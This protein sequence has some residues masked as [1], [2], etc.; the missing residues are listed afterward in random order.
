MTSI[1]YNEAL[2]KINNLE[3]A[4]NTKSNLRA[5]LNK[6]K[7][8]KL[9]NSNEIY[10]Y[11]MN[12]KKDT[13]E[14]TYYS[15]VNSV[16][17]L[18]TK[19]IIPRPNEYDKLKDY[20]KELKLV[21]QKNTSAVPSDKQNDNYISLEELQ[22]KVK[23]IDNPSDRL[24]VSLYVEIPPVRLDY[25]NVKIVDKLKDIPV[26]DDKQNYYAIRENTI[27]LRDYK[28]KKKYGEYQYKL[29]PEH[30]KLIQKIISNTG[31]TYLFINPATNSPYTNNKF[32]VYLTEVFTKYF[33]KSI[34]LLDLRHIYASHY[35]IEKYGMDK[36]KE[37]ANRML[38]SAFANVVE[39]Q[40]NYYSGN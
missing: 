5:V 4:T 28:T 7:K 22:S 8:N 38:H 14:G 13:K 37:I 23:S 18:M 15:Y 26:E 34:T 6:L 9:S 1:N 27:V 39:Y 19:E 29:L 33:N 3:L 12:I 31:Q 32:G 24:L 10:E 20:L 40:K 35:S 11:L 36:V 25:A 2:N 30:K 16:L 21:I 17:S